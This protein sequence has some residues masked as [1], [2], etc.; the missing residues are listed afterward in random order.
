M[1]WDRAGAIGLSTEDLQSIQDLTNDLKEKRKAEST[2]EL[3]KADITQDE[4][5]LQV[6]LDDA[7]FLISLWSAFSRS[8]ALRLHSVTFLKATLFR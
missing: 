4:A 5:K 6:I 2:S 3:V 7:C 1:L 8:V